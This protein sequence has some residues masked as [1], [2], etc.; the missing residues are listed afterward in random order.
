[1]VDSFL[2]DFLLLLTFNLSG[3]FLNKIDT[4]ALFLCLLKLGQ[5]RFS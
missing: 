5:L 4:E 3:Y 1:M 2:R